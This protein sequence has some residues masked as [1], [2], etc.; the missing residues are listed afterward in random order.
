MIFN[1]TLHDP[2]EFEWNFAIIL[3][4]LANRNEHLHILTR[5]AKINLHYF[6]SGQKAEMRD[7]HYERRFNCRGFLVLW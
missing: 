1:Q 6:I 4:K 7:K 5:A 3:K 2:I